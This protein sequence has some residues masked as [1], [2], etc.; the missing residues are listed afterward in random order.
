MDTRGNSGGNGQ[1]DQGK[2]G[3]QP[4]YRYHGVVVVVV[5]VVSFAS[6]TG[7]KEETTIDKDHRHQ[8]GRHD[9]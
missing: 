8:H 1:A 6:A 7:N 2:H 3:R 4:W 9:E 5:V